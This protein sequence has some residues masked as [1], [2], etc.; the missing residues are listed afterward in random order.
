MIS[1]FTGYKAKNS[2]TKWGYSQ[3]LVQVRSRLL[4]AFV[5]WVTEIPYM[6]MFLRHCVV[7]IPT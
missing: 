3:N 1:I 7:E 2:S 5:T 6:I 4:C